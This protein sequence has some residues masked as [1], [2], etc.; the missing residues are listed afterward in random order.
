[1]ATFPQCAVVKNLPQPAITYGPFS[2]DFSFLLCFPEQETEATNLWWTIDAEPFCIPQF[3]SQYALVATC[4]AHCAVADPVARSVADL[5]T[6]VAAIRES[7]PPLKI[8]P[9]LDNLLT[10]AIQSQG[11]PS[12]IDEWARRIADEVGDLTD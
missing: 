1:M 2:D 7:R 6:V 3:A 5:R 8:T 9:N 12:N 10:R 11:P 4:G